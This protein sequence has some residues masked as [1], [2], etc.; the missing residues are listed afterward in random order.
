MKSQVKRLVRAYSIARSTGMFFL[1]I[2]YLSVLPKAVYAQWVQNSGTAGLNVRAFAVSNDT[3]Y[4]G[5][6]TGVLMSTNNGTNWTAINTGLKNTSIYSIVKND[7]L[8]YAGTYSGQNSGIYV[9]SNSGVNWTNANNG[10]P[11]GTSFYALAASA[12]GLVYAG[13]TVGLYATSNLGGVWNLENSG[14]ASYPSTNAL[15]VNGNYVYAGTSYGGVFVSTNNGANWTASSDMANTVVLS[16]AMN[17]NNIYAGTLG[18]GL[19]LSTNNGANWTLL[20]LTYM[21]QINAI[22]ASGKNLFASGYSSAGNFFFSTDNGADWTLAN[23]GLADPFVQALALVGNTLLAGTS[24]NGVFSRHISE[25]LGT[26][27]QKPNPLPASFT[28]NQN[29]PNPFNPS[30]AIRYSLPQAAVVTLKVYDLLGREVATLVNENKAAGNYT[31]SFDAAKLSS[32]T[33]FYKLQARSSGSQAE[34]FV[35]TKK[36][37]LLK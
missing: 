1:F 36:M 6:G 8:L 15:A 25:L 13:T 14:M 35:Q 26:P 22:A 21:G 29:Y 3:V 20:G 28:L 27:S 2:L 30:T 5:T 7:T 18:S 16:L 19:Y 12:G 31:V 23:T 33:Y 37:L 10:L 32:G 34:N 24:G 9:S 17:G 4:A 11:S